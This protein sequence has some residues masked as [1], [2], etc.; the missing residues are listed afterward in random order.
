MPPLVAGAGIGHAVVDSGGDAPHS[1][2]GF[3]R[4]GLGSQA[5]P[6]P[7]NPLLFPPPPWENGPTVAF[8][9]ETILR[10]TQVMSLAATPS[11]RCDLRIA[12]DVTCPLGWSGSEG[13]P[14]SSTSSSSIL[15]MT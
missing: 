7:F 3:T 10:I 4:P 11:L 14:P 9:L 13:S 6:I 8:S 1:V 5:T 15:P 2:V 12:R